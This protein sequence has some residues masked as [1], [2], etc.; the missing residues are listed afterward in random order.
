MGKENLQ[1]ILYD[2]NLINSLQCYIQEEGIFTLII[3]ISK[4][5]V[6]NI[7]DV[8]SKINS[9]VKYYFNNLSKINWNSIYNYVEKQHLILFQHSKI[10]DETELIDDM[11]NNMHD[12]DEKNYYAG[13]KI[14]QKKEYDKLKEEIKN[15]AFENCF[16]IYSL[17]E[18][19]EN[20][21]EMIEPIYNSSYYL[22][23]KSLIRG[24]IEFKFNIDIY[25]KYID[26]KPKI[27]KNL[28]KYLIPSLKNNRI[29][30]GAVS[31]T[32]ESF[33][34]GNIIMSNKFLFNSVENYILTLIS[35]NFINH[36]IS[37][38]FYKEL[39][40]GYFTFYTFNSIPSTIN[41]LIGGFNDKYNDY[42]NDFHKFIKVLSD[43]L[44]NEDNINII[45]MNVNKYKENLLNINKLSPWEYSNIMID[46]AVNNNNYSY[47]KK[48]NLLETIDMG[49]LIKKLQERIKEILLFNNFGVTLLFY[50]NY[51]FKDIPSLDM[52]NKNFNLPTIPLKNTNPIKSI[53]IKNPNN[54]ETNNLYMVLFN[55]GIFCPFNNT[56]LLMIQLLME[57]P[58]Y[59]FLRTKKQLG[60][61]VSSGIVKKYPYY[62]LNI[63]I[64]SEK[65]IK[66]IEEN[67]NQFIKKFIS[68]LQ[69]LDLEKIKTTTK[70]ILE[71]KLNS[72][73]ELNSRYK[74]E[75]NN[76]TF[77]FNREK[78][79]ISQL[80]KI[81]KNDIIQYFNN[82]LNNKSII[83][84][85]N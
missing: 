65:N 72:I 49:V 66:V 4:S 77:M 83:V 40:L 58:S 24:E 37:K 29:W 60:Y 43:Q 55:S 25:S 67:V 12:Y 62:Y 69:D 13:D 26:I 74:T 41:L 76:L 52:Y 61:L 9:Y 6:D 35:L 28:D 59:D 51:K 57:Q 18:K 7:R 19:I 82:I 38:H 23:S 45:K 27:I 39:N 1:Q 84:I 73:E 79:L 33:L 22:I 30:Y 10:T 70:E 17:Q 34:I 63:K 42:F 71:E 15:L 14:I 47:I 8:I 78:I 2:K 3:N 75:I 80:N 16:I 85:N 11:A 81:S 68:I 20:G 48:I 32:N 21:N 64:Q 36:K 31:K 56:I 5:Q 50:G 44:N 53:T 54:K 46:E